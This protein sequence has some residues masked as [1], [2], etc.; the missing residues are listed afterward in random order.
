[1]E[2]CEGEGTYSTVTLHQI[3]L[4]PD[5]FR[6][7]TEPMRTELPLLRRPR[8]EHLFTLLI[9]AGLGLHRFS[10]PGDLIFR[11]FIFAGLM[12]IFPF[13]FGAA[14]ATTIGIQ[15]KITNDNPTI[16]N[17]FMTSPPMTI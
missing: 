9:L 3:P 7:T 16:K 13:H 11:K 5:F 8:F 4:C 17:P 14:S 1:V 10:C 15:E 6:L 2:T 12:P